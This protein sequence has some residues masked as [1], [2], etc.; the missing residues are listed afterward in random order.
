MLAEQGHPSVMMMPNA[1]GSTY[2]YFGM[3]GADVFEAWADA[4]AHYRLDPSQSV[5]SGSSMGGFGTYKLATQFPDLFKA[6]FP[7]IAPEIC[8]LTEAG[9]V[10]E[11]QSGVTAL[12]RTF[13]GL[14]NLPILATAGLNDPLVNYAITSR[15]LT[16]F[17][18]LDL[19]F[20]FWHF[21]GT[22]GGQGHAEY[23]QFVREQYGQFSRTT[24]PI[25]PDPRR[26]SYVLNG[27]VSDARYGL[28]SDHAYWV[29]GLKLANDGAD[30]PLGTIDVTSRA[31]AK[32][33][34]AARPLEPSVGPSQNG[35]NTW[36]RMRRDAI[37][38]EAAPSENAFTMT[39]SNLG[40]ATLDVRRMR[41]PEFGSFTGTVD[42]DAPLRLRLLGAFGMRTRVTVAGASAGSRGA[43]D[44][45]AGT[46]E[47]RVSQPV[48]ITLGRC[49]DRTIRVRV[50]A[51][52]GDRLRS[53]RVTVDGRRVRTVRRRFGR[54]IRVTLP[55]KG[56]RVVVVATTREGR[57]LE[58]RRVGCPANR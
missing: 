34:P 36:T 49:A 13:A 1:R 15:T 3:A 17:D 35:S 32:P 22:E 55:R 12:G 58:R 23:R 42:T 21:Q 44:L 48:P 37:A 10:A 2:C 16:R 56:A 20:D 9:A 47:I 5:I 33:E 53:V 39:A 40:A 11:L 6:I 38:G 14:R 26:V 24:A 30:P 4:A 19:S 28:V 43:V 25:D 51:P 29:S 46:S 45:P 54:P 50:R 57:R 52:R 7:N 27:N 31:I 18:E 8:D 41:L